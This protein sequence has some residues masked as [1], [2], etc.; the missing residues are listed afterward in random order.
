LELGLHPLKDTFGPLTATALW[1]AMSDFLDPSR[2]PEQTGDFEVDPSLFFVL[3]GLGFLIG[4]V[5]HIAQ[6]KVT[7]AIG[8]TMIFLATVLIPLALHV[9]N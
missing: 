9:T 6:S 2:G 7:I 5:G 8:V 1:L 4:V 3:L